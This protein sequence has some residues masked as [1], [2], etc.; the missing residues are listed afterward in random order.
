MPSTMT[1]SNPLTSQKP[2]ENKKPAIKLSPPSN[3][4]VNA[5]TP[6]PTR[7]RDP[8]KTDDQASNLKE[9]KPSFNLDSKSSK[10]V[11]KK[12][13]DLENMNLVSRSY[14]PE[15]YAQ[16]LAIKEDQDGSNQG[17]FYRQAGRPD[18]FDLEADKKLFKIDK[19]SKFG[20]PEIHYQMSCSVL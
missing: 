10:V 8:Y 17:Y 5:G 9:V 19:K 15:A 16:Q 6:E 2:E 4:I 18:Y 20:P 12:T 14:D 11:G 13:A 7:K 1:V 3:Q